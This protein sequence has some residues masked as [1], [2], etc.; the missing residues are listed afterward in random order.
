MI[1]P[2]LKDINIKR[3]DIRDDASENAGEEARDIQDD[4]ELKEELNEL[5]RLCTGT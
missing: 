4:S 5:P 1:S 3:I 2:Y